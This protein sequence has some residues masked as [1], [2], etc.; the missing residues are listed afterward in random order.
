MRLLLARADDRVKEQALDALIRLKA[1]LPPEELAQVA[2]VESAA[3]RGSR[4]MTAYSGLGPDSRIG[5]NCSAN[6]LSMS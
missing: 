3:R 1:K 6:G 4:S 5:R 2:P